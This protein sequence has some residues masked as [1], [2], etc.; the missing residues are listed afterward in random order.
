M[1]D[2]LFGSDPEPSKPY[3]GPQ[4]QN[5]EA[6][7]SQAVMGA[8]AGQNPS[9]MGYMGSS[10]QQP[11][12]S[13]VNPA[14]YSMNS[15]GSQSPWGMPNLAGTKAPVKP[16]GGQPQSSGSNQS[17]PF[18]PQ[19]FQQAGQYIPG[20]MT[21][22]Q[23]NINF[24]ERS[25]YQF[26]QPQNLNV[27]DIYTPQYNMARDSIN[28]QAAETEEQ[29]LANLNARGMLTSGAA[30][31]G[32]MDLAT[33]KNRRLAD[34]S[35]QYSI[36]QGRMQLQEDQMRRQMDM[37]RQVQQAAEIF[38]QQGASDEQAMFL[39]QQSLAGFNANMQ[40][41]Q[42]ATA[43]EQ[44]ANAMRRQPLQDLFQLYGMQT[45]QIGGTEGSQ[46]LIPSMM[47]SAAGAAVGLI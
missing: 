30:N 29:M 47:S 2:F 37:D 46:G 40:G 27:Q 33:E 23:P 15:G 28:Q 18:A 6:M 12:A 13:F 39:A 14:Q 42:Q 45:G 35:S 17:N 31:K 25:P 44:L 43:E 32:V 22:Q 10:N 8:M 34:L 11:Q 24:A 1:G 38:R 16:W 26:T 21:Y 20:Q 3:Q 36:E 41:R 7:L 5:Q 9:L 19:G 4:F